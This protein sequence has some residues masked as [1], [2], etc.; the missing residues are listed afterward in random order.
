MIA[1]D[2]TMVPFR[3][4]LKFKQYIPGKAH[5]YGIKLFKLCGTD[6][7]T[8]Y[9]V[10]IY[11]GKTETE[12]KGLGCRVVLDLCDRYL[13][14]GRTIITDN[15]YTSI[16]L[17]NEL[18]VKDTNLIGTLRSNR[19]K[20]SEVTK[21]KSLAGQI[22]GKENS[23]GLVVAKWRDKRDVT[24]LSTCHNLNMV[25]TGKKNRKNEAVVKP[26][27]IIDYNA[28]KA[29]IDLSDQ[30]S[31]Y[32]SPVRKSIRWYHKVATEIIL[33]TSVVNAL[34]IYN[35]K[36]LQKKMSIT[37]FREALVDQI[38]G[39]DQPKS[40]L[41]Q[42]TP[43]RSSITLKHKFQE[44]SE[45]C[46]RNRKIRKRCTHC[47]KENAARNGSVQACKDT[48]RVTTLCTKCK[49]YTCSNCFFK[50]HSK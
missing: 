26:K 23:N 38:L 4:R 11:A 41:E 8:Y 19:V 10:Q 9:N 27:I 16:V 37:Q 29:G 6:G 47:Y 40:I 32:S 15:F 33:G 42:I 3:G 36:T 30:L 43:P 35:T 48:K 34:I 25:D 49:V 2:E 24:M 18:L 14:I 22:V 39:L 31:S 46:S 50:H 17:A 45:K 21:A 44:T 13:N 1:V 12:G 20:L 5:K 7:Y 28:G